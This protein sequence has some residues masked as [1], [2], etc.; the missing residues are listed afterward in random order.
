[1][2]SL[3]IAIHNGSFSSDSDRRSCSFGCSFDHV[4]KKLL[5]VQHEF[6]MLSPEFTFSL[7]VQRLR[8]VDPASDTDQESGRIS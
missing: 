4:V 7:H 5:E 1:M 8:E 2:M 3:P 6:D